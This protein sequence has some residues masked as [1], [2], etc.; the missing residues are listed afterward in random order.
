MGQCLFYRLVT[1]Y[2]LITKD[3]TSH[4]FIE[5]LGCPSGKPVFPPGWCPISHRGQVEAARFSA[6]GVRVDIGYSQGIVDVLVDI[7]KLN[8]TK[9][10][11]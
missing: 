9:L 6:R 5:P 3:T 4:G 2:G 11:C 10:W 8:I 7:Y 1:S